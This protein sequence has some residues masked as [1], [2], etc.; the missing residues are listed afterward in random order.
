MRHVQQ[1]LALAQDTTEFRFNFQMISGGARHACCVAIRATDE[2]KA[3]ALFRENWPAI[4]KLARKNL[5]SNA[6]NK[7]RLP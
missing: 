3:A 7:I 1:V 5:A 6:A 2:A 4:E